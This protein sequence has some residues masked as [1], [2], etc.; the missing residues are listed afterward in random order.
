MAALWGS[1]GPRGPLTTVLARPP[2][3]PGAG[4][5]QR[6]GSLELA[7]GGWRVVWGFSL[8]GGP[9]V[10]CAEQTFEPDV[11]N[12]RNQFTGELG[13]QTSHLWAG[14]RIPVAPPGVQG[15]RFG[16]PEASLRSGTRPAQL[17]AWSRG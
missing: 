9:T 6:L 1:I 10:L 16:K 17:K 13:S 2:L 5:G 12:M 11:G 7:G 15:L 8:P 4:C 14:G 3:G